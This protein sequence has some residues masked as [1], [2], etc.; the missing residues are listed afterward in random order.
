VH[1]DVFDV[2]RRK[3]VAIAYDADGI[4][5]R[6]VARGGRIELERVVHGFPVI[7]EP[8]GELVQLEAVLRTRESR[9]EAAV[10]AFEHV[11]DPGIAD[12][13]EQSGV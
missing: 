5:R 13:C 2:V 4:E 1:D 12:A 11:L 8:L 3:R 9:A 10:L 7:A 6:V